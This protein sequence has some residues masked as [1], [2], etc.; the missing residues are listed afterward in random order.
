VTRLKTALP[1]NCLLLAVSIV[2]V[3]PCQGTEFRPVCGEDPTVVFPCFLF[4]CY[5]GENST[6]SFRVENVA[7]AQSLSFYT[8]LDDEI[9]LYFQNYETEDFLYSV[10]HEE[11][12]DY[13]TIQG[14]HGALPGGTLEIPFS[15]DIDQRCGATRPI[16]VFSAQIR[17]ASGE[18]NVLDSI[19]GGVFSAA[20][21][22]SVTFA[23]GEVFY[24]DGL[25]RIPNA[26]VEILSVNG[27]AFVSAVAYRGEEDDPLLAHSQERYPCRFCKYCYSCLCSRYLRSMQ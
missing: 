22:D 8:N 14:R 15:V 12:A 13:H 26:V 4:N 1:A 17:L 18:S 5:F 2:A 20:I 27:V 23:E 6:T 19:D 10:V 11:T 3:S 24:S 25:T 21:D 16:F 9:D 7:G